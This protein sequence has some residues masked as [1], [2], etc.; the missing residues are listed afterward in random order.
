MGGGG[1]LKGKGGLCHFTTKKGWT[2]NVLAMLKG[3]KRKNILEF[4]M[5]VGQ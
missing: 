4:F 3:E 5:V 2:E 1:L